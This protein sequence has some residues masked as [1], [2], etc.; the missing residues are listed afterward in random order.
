MMEPFQTFI[1]FVKNYEIY[2]TITEGQSLFIQASNRE[3]SD[4]V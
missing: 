1:V 3:T 2:E 4:A